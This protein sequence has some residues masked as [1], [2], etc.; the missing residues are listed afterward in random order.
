MFLS[1][2]VAIQD[3]GGN[4]L[5]IMS[6]KP[7][8]LALSGSTRSGSFNTR[9][10]HVAAAAAEAAGAEVKVVDLK[11]YPLPIY[12][13]DL[14]QAEGL[15]ENAA[16]LQALFAEHDGLIIASPEYNGFF[17]PLLKNTLDWISR[18]G[19]DTPDPYQGKVAMLVSASPGGLG[20]MRG[21]PHLRTLLSNLGVITLA[22]QVS[23]SSAHGGFADDRLLK[24][25]HK[26]KQMETLAASLVAMLVKLKG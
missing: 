26:Q 21:L 7:A 24:E 15:P 10:L 20:G 14:E 8:I 5:W 2:P 19:E 25:V 12:N 9:A 16:Q 6:T 23:I 13:G 17:T 4:S 18:T 11:E 3:R 22:G 1:T